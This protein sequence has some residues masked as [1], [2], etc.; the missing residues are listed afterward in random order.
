MLNSKQRKYL[1]SMTIDMQP[2]VNI[3]KSSLTPEIIASV[4]EALEARELIKVSILK[5]CP[6]VTSQ[7]AITLSERTRS[8]VVRIIGKK[9]VLY[10]PSKKSKIVL[11]E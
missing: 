5:N 1:Y 8:E 3:G 11:P 7:L 6:D 4:D 9:L 10:R 2:V